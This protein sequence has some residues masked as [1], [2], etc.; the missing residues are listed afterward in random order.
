M[1]HY[2]ALAAGILGAAAPGPPEPKIKDLLPSKRTQRATFE[3]LF[4]A[5]SAD[6]KSNIWSNT[7]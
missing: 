7:S 2:R 6:T 3:A 4:V 5:F 1:S